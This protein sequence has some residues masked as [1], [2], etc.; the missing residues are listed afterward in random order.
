MAEHRLALEHPEAHEEHR[1][2]TSEKTDWGL[3][4]VS[5]SQQNFRK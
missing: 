5:A 2:P 1:S 3:T 4:L